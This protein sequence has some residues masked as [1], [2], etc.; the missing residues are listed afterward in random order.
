MA[1]APGPD[2]LTAC[3]P[4]SRAERAWVAQASGMRSERARARAVLY[5]NVHAAV[6]FGNG[7][8]TGG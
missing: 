5:S 4:T 8:Q 3:L 6:S 7:I 2:R 1:L